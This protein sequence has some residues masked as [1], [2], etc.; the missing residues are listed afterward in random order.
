MLRLRI[1]SAIYLKNVT[2]G[3]HQSDIFGSGYE[4]SNDHNM[5]PSVL[6]PSSIGAVCY[7]GEH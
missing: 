5:T 7:A 3:L 4:T 2:F 6:I 1:L